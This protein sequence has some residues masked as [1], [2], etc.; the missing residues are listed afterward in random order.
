MIAYGLL[1]HTGFGGALDSE[2]ILDFVDAGHDL[3]LAV[4]T[5][6]SDE[7]RNLASDLGVDFEQQGSAVIDTTNHVALSK[8][9][10]A[11]LVTS[12]QL[13][14]S[15]AILGE[16]IIKVSTLPSSLQ[17]LPFSLRLVTPQICQWLFQVTEGCEAEMSMSKIRRQRCHD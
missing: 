11:T 6:A 2:A 12:Q 13:L 15:P 8:A 4:D 16:S 9:V 14:Q 7:V 5:K 1:L 10:D 3:I 17:S